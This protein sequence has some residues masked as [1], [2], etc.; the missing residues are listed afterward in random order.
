MIHKNLFRVTF[1]IFFSLLG[2]NKKE[3]Q[4][5][6]TYSSDWFSH[7]IPIW[8]K[9]LAPF[10]N[11]QNVKYLE[12]GVF[13]GRSAFWVLNEILTGTGSQA[14]LVDIFRDDV[15]KIFLKNLSLQ[16]NKHKVKVIKGSSLF[17]LRNLDLDSYDIIY[18]DGSH[19]AKDVFVDLA[20]SWLLLKKG[21]VLIFDDY[22]WQKNEY[23]ITLRPHSPINAFITAFSSDIDVL[24]RAYQILIRKKERISYNKLPFGKI[25]YDWNNFNFTTNTGKILY[26]PDKEELELIKEYFFSQQYGDTKPTI[27]T[28]LKSSVKFQNLLKKINTPVEIL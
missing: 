6:P 28:K 9:H 19:M 21:G 4:E 10:K 18:I 17:E 7:N 25:L 15:E 13:E 5:Y 27:T 1:L 24:H 14:T 16:K 22:E 26:S 8:E 3:T 12:I 23:P 20:Q 2:C 11:R